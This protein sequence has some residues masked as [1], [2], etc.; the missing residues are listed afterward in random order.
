MTF[1]SMTPIKPWC[2]GKHFCFI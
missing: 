1:P 2:F